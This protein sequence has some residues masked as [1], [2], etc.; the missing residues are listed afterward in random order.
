MALFIE[1]DT[2]IIDG[3][4]TV[5]DAHDDAHGY[6]ATLSEIV[7]ILKVVEEVGEV[8]AAVI[9]VTGQNPRKGVTHTVLDVKAELADTILTAMVAL[10]TL[11]RTSW[12]RYLL[13]AFENKGN[14]LIRP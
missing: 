10:A 1:L 2:A 3:I 14:R 11:D 9:G 13:K 8:A 4:V 6:P 7:R 5:L 12:S